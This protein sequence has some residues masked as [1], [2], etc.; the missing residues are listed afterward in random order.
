MDI[1]TTHALHTQ[2]AR[3]RQEENRLK[4]L[5]GATRAMVNFSRQVARDS[6]I[7]RRL[8]RAQRQVERIPA[9]LGL[10]RRQAQ[11]LEKLVYELEVQPDARSLLQTANLRTLTQFLGLTAHLLGAG[12]IQRFT[13]EVDNLLAALQSPAKPAWPIPAGPRPGPLAHVER[14]VDGDTILLAGGWRVRYI[15]MDT[16]EMRGENNNPE[17]YALEACQVNAALVEGRSVR[18]V[19]DASDTD[20]YGRL[21]RY[22]YAGETFVNA[23]LV[24]QGLAYAFPLPP[25]TQYSSLFE[26]LERDAR[27][28]KLGMWAQKA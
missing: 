1:L 2:I 26:N 22:V 9:T 6:A 4:K 21:L 17:P 10:V 16:P 23:E 7:T 24:R 13:R 19:R 25:D 20:R 28:K 27:K 15:G 14:V 8:S 3:L 18:L 12:E 11:L 5:L